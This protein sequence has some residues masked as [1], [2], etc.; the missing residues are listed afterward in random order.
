MGV[1]SGASGTEALGWL[2]PL[3]AYGLLCWGDL[4]FQPCPEHLLC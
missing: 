1:V 2:C 4:C 3:R